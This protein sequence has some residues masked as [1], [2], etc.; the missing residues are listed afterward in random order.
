MEDYTSYKICSNSSILFL[1][2][3]TGHITYV[4][5]LT[6][7]S[8]FEMKDIEGIETKVVKG[9]TIEH[10]RT[11]TVVK[12]DGSNLGNIIKGAATLNAFGFAIL[13]SPQKRIEKETVKHTFETDDKYYVS[14]RYHV[15]R[16]TDTLDVQTL[17]EKEM[18][19][20]ADYLKKF[21]ADYR[22][23]N[24]DPEEEEEYF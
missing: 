18:N 24:S 5:A 11:R 22:A 14:I 13:S 23:K 15:G 7:C 9:S 16:I 17:D 12:T 20:V 3:K 21:V 1:N 4:Y 19:E 6:D 2:D 10:Y 8:P